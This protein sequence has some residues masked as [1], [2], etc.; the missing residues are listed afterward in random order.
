MPRPTKLTAAVADQIVLAVK[1]CAAFHAAAAC[2][3]VSAATFHA[4]MA[5]GRAAPAGGVAQ[6]SPRTEAARK[7]RAGAQRAAAPQPSELPFLE[8]VGRV[9][10]ADVDAY[11]LA[12]VRRGKEIRDAAAQGQPI[13]IEY[14]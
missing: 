4:W 2:A 14:T 9:E 10:Q 12:K 1:G 11:R 13:M 7:A 3:G 6:A 8:F 5:G